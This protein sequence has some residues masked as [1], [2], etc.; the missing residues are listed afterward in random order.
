[1]LLN[2]MAR[3]PIS[4]SRSTF[5]GDEIPF[6]D[7]AAVPARSARG[8]AMLRVTSRAA[9]TAKPMPSRPDGSSDAQHGKDRLERLCLFLLGDQRRLQL[10]QPAIGPHHR[11]TSKIP[12]S[13]ELEA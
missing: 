12:Y 2:A 9:M 3:A 13:P 7:L 8:V 10:W 6:G 4:S 5:A 1:M 11:R